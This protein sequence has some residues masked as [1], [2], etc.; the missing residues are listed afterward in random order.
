MRSSC[1][2]RRQPLVQRD[3]DT[4]GSTNVA[5]HQPCVFSRTI[6]QIPN[7]RT[8]ELCN[9]CRE[10]D[11]EDLFCNE[12]PGMTR[13]P[14]EVLYLGR[15]EKETTC[16][17]CQFFYSM[18]WG[19]KTKELPEETEVYT[20]RSW[21]LG[22]RYASSAAYSASHHAPSRVLC[23]FSGKPSPARAAVPFDTPPPERHWIVPQSS[24]AAPFFS[25]ERSSLSALP[26]STTSINYP[27]LRAWCEQCDS[28]HSEC[29]SARKAKHGSDKQRVGPAV[30]C[31]DC[32]TRE[33]V[34]IAT[35][36]R[37]FA[38]SYV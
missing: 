13:K 31:I 8:V 28:H 20:L 36:D 4:A 11:L 18:R 37:F 30:R 35:S 10:I 25:H 22:N 16:V 23:V 3:R 6:P 29:A 15:L 38:L 7:K 9:R 26:F 33:I 1:S 32:H 17:L 24:A 19:P 5:L 12:A 2:S 14:K 21:F 34:E 27:L